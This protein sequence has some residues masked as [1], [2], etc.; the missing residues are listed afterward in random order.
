MGNNNSS[1]V[2]LTFDRL[3]SNF[4]AGELVSGSVQFEMLEQFDKVHAV[5]LEIVGEAGYTTEERRT[6]TVDAKQ[7]VE[8]YAKNH[9]VLFLKTRITVKRREAG[10]QNLPL[11]PGII[12]NWPFQVQL[13]QH[14]PPTLHEVDYPYIKYYIQSVIDRPWYKRNS[15]WKHALSI[16]PDMNLQYIPD[17][18]QLAQFSN[19]NREEIDIQ[20]IFPKLGYVP[21]ETLVSTIEIKNP[22]QITIKHIQIFLYQHYR[23]QNNAR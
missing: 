3:N 2:V 10:E 7:K 21:N 8:I 19:A 16:F 15:E 1:R 9:N 18:Q 12:Y 13:P 22:N 17:V 14:L 23:I 20:I 11:V 6:I 4:L 5:Y